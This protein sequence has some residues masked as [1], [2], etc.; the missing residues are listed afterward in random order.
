MGV[1]R[2]AAPPPPPPR[3]AAWLVVTVQA[4][5]ILVAKKLRLS[6]L[7]GPNGH[8]NPVGGTIVLARVI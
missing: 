1:V 4:L 2:A 7:V 5:A 8:S 3:S 6:P